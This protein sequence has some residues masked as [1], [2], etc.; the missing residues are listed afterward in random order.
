[1]DS[2][3]TRP[4]FS[5]KGLV[6]DLHST[7]LKISEMSSRSMA[8]E[9]LRGETLELFHELARRACV[10]IDAIQE[11]RRCPSVRH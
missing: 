3:H 4:Q 11:M 7:A 5:E 8:A 2:S 1:M 6:A 9:E 10:T